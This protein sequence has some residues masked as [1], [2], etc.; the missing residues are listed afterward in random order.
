MNWEGAAGSKDEAPFV[1][2]EDLMRLSLI[3]YDG[4]DPLGVLFCFVLSFGLS[5]LPR[6]PGRYCNQLSR[7]APR[8]PPGRRQIGPL[9]HFAKS[10]LLSCTPIVLNTIIFFAKIYAMCLHSPMFWLILVLWGGRI[11]S[12]SASGFINLSV[13][14]VCPTPAVVVD[15]NWHWSALGLAVHRQVTKTRKQA[16]HEIKDKICRL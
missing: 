10:Y 1:L 3:F 7:L 15:W 13:L 6:A 9:G 12:I 8:P 14:P 11:R 2:N 5:L 16:R 4:R